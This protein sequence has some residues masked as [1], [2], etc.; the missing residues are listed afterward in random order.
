MHVHQDRWN[1]GEGGMCSPV[2]FSDF[3]RLANYWL[4]LICNFTVS[5]LL[6]IKLI[7]SVCFHRI[8]PKILV[9]RPLTSRLTPFFLV[10]GHVINHSKRNLCPLHCTETIF[11][12]IRGGGIFSSRNDQKIFMNVHFVWRLKSG[13]KTQP[14]NEPFE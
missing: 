6:K 3:F 7:R 5:G 12:V 2:T 9:F 14:F 1:W 11:P 13:S 4:V 8:C 10:W